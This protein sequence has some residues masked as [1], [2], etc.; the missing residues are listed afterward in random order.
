MIKP[1]PEAA[2]TPEGIIRV[3]EF[4]HYH[5]SASGCVGGVLLV[6]AITPG[7]ERGLTLETC[8]GEILRRVRPSSVSPCGPGCERCAE[9]ATRLAREK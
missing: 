3:G 2:S 1:R 9:S 8:T 6:K 7:Q 5:G 4:V